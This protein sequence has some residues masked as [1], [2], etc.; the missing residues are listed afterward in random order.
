MRNIPETAGRCQTHPPCRDGH[1]LQ[2]VSYDRPAYGGFAS[3]PG[4]VVADCAGDVRAI[5]GELGIGRAAG[6]GFSGGGPHLTHELLAHAATESLRTP[7][8]MF[9]AAGLPNG[10][11]FDRHSYSAFGGEQQAPTGDPDYYP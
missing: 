1:G 11:C 6:W 10:Y 9:C 2:L 3:M 5:L 7:E 8:Q 4:R